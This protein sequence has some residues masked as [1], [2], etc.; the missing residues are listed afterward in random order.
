MQRWGDGAILDG[1]EKRTTAEVPVLIVG[2]GPVG[3]SAALLLARHGV[4][5]LLVERHPTT[6]RLPKARLV[7]T[8]TMEVFRQCGIES[9]V[10]R[11]GLPPSSARYL[12]RARSV[13]GEELDR[14]EATFTPGAQALLSPT[15]VCTCPQNLLE[16]VLLAAVQD[17]G[18]TQVIS[19]TS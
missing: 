1:M 8:R 4:Q 10:Q 2:G 12:I 7:N 15:T 3:L 13:A 14:R 18:M 5:S 17:S 6:S 16:P 11:A 9:E 19:G